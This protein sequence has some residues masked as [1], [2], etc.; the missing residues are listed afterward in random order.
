M[1]VLNNKEVMQVSGG[2]FSFNGESGFSCLDNLIHKLLGIQ[3]LSQI[4]LDMPPAIGEQPQ[5]IAD[6]DSAFSVTPQ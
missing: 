2:I 3:P 5:L 1:K 6:V 4:V